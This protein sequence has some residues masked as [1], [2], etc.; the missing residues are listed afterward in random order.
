MTDDTIYL[1]NHATT[2]CDPLVV[3][4]MLPLLTDVYGNPHSTAH[5]VGQAASDEVQSALQGI[6]DCLGADVQEFIVTSGATESNNLALLGHCLNPRNTKRHLITVSTEHHAV[7]DP[8]ESLQSQGFDVTHLNVDPAGL[9]DLDCLA[10]S[11]RDDT[12]LISI[13]WANNEIGT[14]QP[15]GQIVQIAHD[16]GVP[17]HT[18]ATQAIGRIPVDLRLVPVDMMSCSAH[19]FYGP[20]GAGLLYVRR[21]GRLAR[22]RPLFFGGGQ[23]RRMRPGTI[24]PAAVVG[25]SVALKRCCELMDDES[26]RFEQLAQTMFEQLG[27]HIP[28]LQLNGP[29]LHRPTRLPG[30]LNL[31]FP[32]VQ[33]QSIM[34]AAPSIAVSSG[35]ACSSAE[36]RPSHV[37]SGIGLSEQQAKQSLRIGIG[38][39]NTP[40]EVQR[41]TCAIV[42]AYRQLLQM[43]G[44]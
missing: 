10:A 17:V 33:G 41:A 19:K 31:M 30:N 34:A 23:Q 5:A 36:P 21:Q 27:E 11:I 3:Q 15:M 2:R 37:L 26:S 24:N 7:L 20:K 14:I 44:Q 9:I 43:V 39:F 22:I 12:A 13:M 42:D 28:G 16:R 25:F 29:P 38:R 4:A 18:D 1:D 40:Q 6:A 8:I 32:H 35:S